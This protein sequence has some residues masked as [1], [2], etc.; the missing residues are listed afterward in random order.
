MIF[1]SKGL[2]GFFSLFGALESLPGVSFDEV[3]LGGAGILDADCLV[4]ALLLLL[5][6]TPTEDFR[7]EA[8]RFK[9]GRMNEK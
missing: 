7:V 6:F 8:T 9:K 2:A 5:V 1:D 4:N 3:V